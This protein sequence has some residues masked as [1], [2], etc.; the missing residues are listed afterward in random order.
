MEG[1]KSRLAEFEA[2]LASL[3]KK[4]D[5]PARH[6]RIEEL[7]SQS[8]QAGF[9]QNRERAQKL[10]QEMGTLNNQ[11]EEF[12]KLEKGLAE[13][14]ELIESAGKEKEGLEDLKA[15]VSLLEKKLGRAELATY[16]AGKYDRQ[17]AIVSIHAGQ[18]GVE[19]MDWAQMLKRQYLRHAQRR[20]WQVRIVDETKG[21]EA[22]IKSTTFQVLGLYAYGFLKG[23]AG[24]HRLVRQ[25]PF[26]ADHLRQTSFARVE[27][28]PKIEEAE[29]RLDPDEIEMETFR[30]SGPGGQYVNKVAT[31]VRLRHRPTGIVVTSQAERHQEQN[32]KIAQ[33]LLLAKLWEKQQQKQEQE[34][35]RLKGE[36]RVAGWGNQIRSYVLHPYKMVKDLRTGY[37]TSDVGAVL[38][39]GLD[40]FIEAELRTLSS[41]ALSG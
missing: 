31:G 38:D 8:A 2:R 14:R 7:E 24:T 39:G 25:S 13:A 26:N 21:E 33:D 15:E 36:Y 28:L 12:E 27:V 16:L 11:I 37:Q 5:L 9:W 19:A 32:R 4:L 17:D 23:E 6:L 22:G 41:P 34:K 30:S 29:V 40:G 35:K 3:K 18:G 1:I 20:G 10:L